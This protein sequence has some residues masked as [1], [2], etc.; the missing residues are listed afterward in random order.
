MAR[1]WTVSEIAALV[2]HSLLKAQTNRN[3][4]LRHCQEA[5]SYGFASVCVNPCWVPLCVTELK[6]S[7]IPVCTV[8][9]FP[10]GAATTES[11]AFEAKL[12]ITQGAKEI[13]VVINIGKA[14]SGDWKAVAEDLKAVVDAAR[15]AIVKAIIETCHLNPEEKILACRAAMA[16]DADFVM[17]STGFGTGGAT[18]D[19]LSLLRQTAGKSLQVKASGG[20]RT[21]AEAITMLEAGAT[22]IGTSAGV[23]LVS[24]IE[25]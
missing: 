1:K 6:G 18:L 4:I 9:G 12:A 14:K 22:R 2:D 7:G 13:D 5:R 20:I 24:E 17:T 19:D 25:D 15:P 3:E 16:A 21:R 8:V 10:L 23:A 11:K